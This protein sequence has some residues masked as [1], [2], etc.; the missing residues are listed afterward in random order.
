MSSK[1]LCPPPRR[2]GFP[3]IKFPAH[4][5]RFTASGT[6]FG[7]CATPFIS[8][9]VVVGSNPCTQFSFFFDDEHA[10]SPPSSNAA[11]V[12]RRTRK[13]NPIPLP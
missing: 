9:A 4:S 5:A 7:G 11:A 3:T 13:Q 2:Y 8:S 10:D 1:L 6:P 12:I